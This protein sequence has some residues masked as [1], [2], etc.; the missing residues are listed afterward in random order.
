LRLAFAAVV[1]GLWAVAAAQPYPA[2]PV[3]IIV[4]DAPTS[5]TDI[6]ARLVALKLTD[7][8]SED[9]VVENRA[10]VGGT[11]GTA[12]VAKAEPNGQTLLV[13]SDSHATNLHLFR[14]LKYDTVTD[15]APVSL[16]ARVPLVLVVNP[17]VPARTVSE[18]VH[19]ARAKPGAVDFATFGP[20]SQ[21][22]LLMEMLKL[23]AR[24]EVTNV[25]YRGAGQALA[26]L[27]GGRVDAT[28]QTVP[29]VAALVKAGRLRALAVTSE[30]PSAALP[31]VPVMKE[32]YPDYV[33]QFW[34]GMLAPAK[35]PPAIIA[36]LNAEVV[37]VL[38]S[39]ELRTR[40]G[41]LG[42]EAVG[43]TTSELDQWI[44]LE[45]ERWG[46]VIRSQKITVE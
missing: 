4:P 27:V 33:A 16:L 31:G 15:F 41:N 12:E 6:S 37:K 45:M 1:L 10:G 36:R 35:T 40:F 44:H 43:S 30:T 20:G 11:I 13:I 34:V 3:R 22:R 42:L 21:A 18:L 38:R 25:A 32:Y 19:L 2:G 24:V 14:N 46:K 39:E 23:E 29:G 9:V 17:N 28:F 7:A 26:D 5:L 8:L